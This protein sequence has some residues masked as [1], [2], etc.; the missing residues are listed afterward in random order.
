[1]GGLVCLLA[2][3]HKKLL[4]GFPPN[5]DG[6]Q[7]SVQN[8]PRYC[9]DLAILIFGLISQGIMHGKEPYLVGWHPR[10]VTI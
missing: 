7:T 9:A 1:M 5:L 3:L 8:A 6:A 4:N 10:V 2:G